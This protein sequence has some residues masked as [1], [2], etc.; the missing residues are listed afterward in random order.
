MRSLHLADLERRAA[1]SVPLASQGRVERD[2]RRRL[3]EASAQAPVQGAQAAGPL[4]QAWQQPCRRCAAPAGEACQQALALNSH[5]SNFDRGRS[6][7]DVDNVEAEELRAAAD[8]QP[9]GP[10]LIEEFRRQRGS[11]NTIA[12]DFKRGVSRGP[13][14]PGDKTFPKTVTYDKPCGQVSFLSF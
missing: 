3:A 7:F 10:Q 11:F 8:V 2:G 1:N 9:L 12:G 5:C 6:I 4:Q 13:Q 14:V